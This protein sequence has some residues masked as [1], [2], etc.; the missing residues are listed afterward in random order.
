MYMDDSRRLQSFPGNPV[1]TLFSSYLCLRSTYQYIYRFSHD[2]ARIK[3]YIA[4]NGIGF[5]I[6]FEI[7]KQTNVPAD[8]HDVTFLISFFHNI[9]R[10][11]RAI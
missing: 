9:N 8:I 4:I 7:L 6:S 11:P 10:L 1:H 2:T 3:R 5:A